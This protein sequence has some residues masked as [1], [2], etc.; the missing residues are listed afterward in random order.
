MWWDCIGMM[1]KLLEVIIAITIIYCPGQSGAWFWNPVASW[2]IFVHHVFC[3]GC[4]FVIQGGLPAFWTVM[5][6]ETVGP[7]VALF[8]GLL[9]SSSSSSV[10]SS[11]SSTIA[12][13]LLWSLVRLVLV[14]V[15]WLVWRLLLVGSLVVGLVRGW[16]RVILRSRGGCEFWVSLVL[17]SR[18]L[19]SGLSSVVQLVLHV[20]YL[21]GKVLEQLLYV[22]VLLSFLG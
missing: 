10:S 5:C 7:A 20:S 17:I 9:L 22:G 16:G 14:V 11:S 12:F 4:I 21:R 15:L 3:G 8:S 1:C 19:L 18:M 2:W 6:A 13:I